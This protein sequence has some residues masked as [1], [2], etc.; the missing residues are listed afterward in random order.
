M[1]F[2][3]EKE[4]E[5]ENKRDKTELTMDILLILKV[6]KPCFKLKLTLVMN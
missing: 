4:K 1:L 5:R 2:E 6:M 3:L